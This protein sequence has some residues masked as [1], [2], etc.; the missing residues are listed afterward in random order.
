ML[1][2]FFIYLFSSL[3]PAVHGLGSGKILSRHS[4]LFLS[5]LFYQPP[6]S[7]FHPPP[8]FLY[9]SSRSP[10]ILA[11][12]FPFSCVL[13]IFSPLLSL[14][15]CLHPSLP[16]GLLISP[17]FSPIFLFSCPV[18][19]HLLSSGHSSFFCQPSLF[20][21]FDEPSC[22]HKFAAAVVVMSTPLSPDNTGM[23]V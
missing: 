20:L 22:S 7:I 11:V 6:L 16:C 19:S 8:I 17:C 15:V 2:T 10:S 21:L 13:D 14:L 5:I 4:L 18:A 12:G 23:L 9:P 3:F 1:I